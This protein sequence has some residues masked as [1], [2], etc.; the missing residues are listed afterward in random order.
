MR[1][2]PQR[3]TSLWCEADSRA[4]DAHVGALVDVALTLVRG[5]QAQCVA[6]QCH[7]AL[8]QPC[9]RDIRRQHDAC[10]SPPLFP[11]R[12]TIRP[13]HDA[14]HRL[15]LS[16]MGRYIPMPSSFVA[17][18]VSLDEDL[19]VAYVFTFKSLMALKTHEAIV[20]TRLVRGRGGT[21]HWSSPL[22]VRGVM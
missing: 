7:G 18:S 4:G 19:A 8:M 22:L 3:R 5:G 13:L 9:R 11:L 15:W 12:I 1:W 16:A 20:P 14:V 6:E 2:R 10:P 17:C 21:I